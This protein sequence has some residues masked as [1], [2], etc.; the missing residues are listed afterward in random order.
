MSLHEYEDLNDART[1][2]A[3]FL[4]QIYIAKQLHPDLNYLLLLSLKL[5][6]RLSSLKLES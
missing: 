4:D 2:I 5:N 6:S 1:H 3:H